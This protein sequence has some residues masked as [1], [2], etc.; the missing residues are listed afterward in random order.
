VHGKRIR[1]GDITHK[2]IAKG[3]GG[4][5]RFFHDVALPNRV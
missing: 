3:K 4:V 2:R 1:V 5:S